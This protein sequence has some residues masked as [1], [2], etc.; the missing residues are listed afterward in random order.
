M[1]FSL[2]KRYLH[3]LLNVLQCWL[4]NTNYL[5]SRKRLLNRIITTISIK[6]SLCFATGLLDFINLT[7]NFLVK[8]QYET[9][10]TIKSI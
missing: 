10:L 5:A 3:I 9:K 2:E 8:T 7:F 1:L 4:I 6:I